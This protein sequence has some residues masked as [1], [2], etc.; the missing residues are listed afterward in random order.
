MNVRL[1]GPLWTTPERSADIAMCLWFEVI[2]VVY[3]YTVGRK[4]VR[5]YIYINLRGYMER[6]DT[7]VSIGVDN[8]MRNGASCLGDGKHGTSEI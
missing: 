4:R 7:Y 3:M 8:I 2:V 1:V 5:I 6:R